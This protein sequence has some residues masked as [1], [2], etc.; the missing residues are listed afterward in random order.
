M[1]PPA[2][3]TRIDRGDGS[4]H[5]N[6]LRQT[7]K[8]PDLVFALSAQAS[9]ETKRFRDSP[10]PIPGSDGGWLALLEWSGTLR[11]AIAVGGDRT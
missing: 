2:L 4:A 10:R 5:P 6:S 8:T 11:S 1:T 3:R 7:S 9:G